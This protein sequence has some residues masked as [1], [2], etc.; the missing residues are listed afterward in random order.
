MCVVVNKV[1]RSGMID[2]PKNR[3]KE[4]DI[5]CG[6]GN[7]NERVRGIDHIVIMG[8]CEAILM[9]DSRVYE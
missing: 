9:L 8:Y 3:R 6:N 1:I 5:G 4:K 7:G 2:S